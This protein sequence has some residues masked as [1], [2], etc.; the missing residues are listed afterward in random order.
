VAT[1]GSSGRRRGPVR[2]VARRGDATGVLVALGLVICLACGVVRWL[3]IVDL[4]AGPS[5]P[6]S[7]AS[8]APA[9]PAPAGGL[10]DEAEAARSYPGDSA[11][12]VA[13][14]K[15]MG[16][17]AASGGLPPELPVMAALVE[18]SLT[19]HQTFTDHDSLGYF[20]MRVS[21]WMKRYPDFPVH[22]E[23]QMK[24]FIDKALAVKVQRLKS[25][26]ASFLTDSSQWGRWIADIENPKEEYR[27]RYQTRLQEARQLL[28]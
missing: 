10:F 20:Q 28:S 23:R 6:G 1:R 17:W 8:E 2:R 5:G 25:G 13:I 3:G 4:P 16:R 9:A 18:S 7:S 12:K 24:W 14:A 22:P 26:N 11:P 27:G 15:W 19:N 21:I